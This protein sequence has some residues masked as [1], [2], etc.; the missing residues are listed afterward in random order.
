MLTLCRIGGEG[1]ADFHL[2]GCIKTS[3]EVLSRPPPRFRES[4]AHFPSKFAVIG[5]DVGL[6]FNL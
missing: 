4:L 3:E 2:L 6:V 5:V 1:G